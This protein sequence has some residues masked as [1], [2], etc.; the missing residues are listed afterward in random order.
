MAGGGNLGKN[1]RPTFAK[2]MIGFHRQ[3]AVAPAS[4]AGRAIGITAQD[5]ANRLE[6]IDTRAQKL[7]A[8][9]EGVRFAG[10]IRVYDIEEAMRFL[11]SGAVDQKRYTMGADNYL[12]SLTLGA[13]DLDVIIVE[14][15]TPIWTMA[16]T[17]GRSRRSVAVGSRATAAGVAPSSGVAPP[18]RALVQQLGGLS[19][20]EISP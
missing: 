4:A 17:T 5:A 16:M 14:E 7:G 19:V 15:V 18:A 6:Q 9:V 1:P 10:Q 2:K 20:C 8:T 13:T 12:M 3:L 11:R